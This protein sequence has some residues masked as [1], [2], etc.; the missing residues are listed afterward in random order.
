MHPSRSLPLLVAGGALLL[1]AGVALLWLSEPG[2]DGRLANAAEAGATRLAARGT[3]RESRGSARADPEPLDASLGAAALRPTEGAP[4]ALAEEAARVE[5][6]AASANADASSACAVHGR[7]LDHTGAGLAALTVQLFRG[8]DELR[9]E[10]DAEGRFAFRD[11]RRGTYRLCIDGASLPAGLRLLPPWKQQLTRRYAGEATGVYGTAF[12]LD[13]ASDPEV[14][15]RVF[16]AG[17][18]RGRVLDSRRQPIINALVA[19]HSAEGMQDAAHTDVSGRFVFDEAYP[20][21][22]VTSV[23][24]SRARAG[25]ALA[26]QPLQFELRPGGEVQLEDLVAGI[27]GHRLRG[28]V[29]DLEGRPVPGLELLIQEDSDVLYRLRW[30]VVTGADGRFE[31]ERLPSAALLLSVGAAELDL[32]REQRLLHENPAPIA[33]DTRGAPETIDLPPITVQARHPALVRGEVR[34][35]TL[36]AAR[37]GTGWAPRIEL[38][39]SGQDAPR[40]LDL[41][42]LPADWP[43]D[44]SG[45]ISRSFTWTCAT[46]HP[47]VQF[48]AVLKDRRGV[49]HEAL[50]QWTPVADATQPLLLTF[51]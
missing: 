33:V 30:T 46:P 32:P 11:L 39:A 49:E 42:P 36:W 14:N 25:E 51:P 13:D 5:P 4:S 45:I 24:L 22:Y 28:L 21:A 12:R 27:G 37:Q 38:R 10:T 34:I 44:P 3:S 35:D 6:A 50:A 17:T 20:G 43:D 19:I 7:V 1:L 48:R 16:Q 18:V 47:P 8:R 26:P 9:A 23:D 29:V 41:G 40:S 2:A 31:L 15:L